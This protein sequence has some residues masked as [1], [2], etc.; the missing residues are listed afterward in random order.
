MQA[1]SSETDST[2]ENTKISTLAAQ[3]YDCFGVVP[4]NATNVIT[5]LVPVAKKNIPDPEPGHPDRCGRVEGR[6]CLLRIVHRFGQPVGGPAGRPG[7]DEGH[8][9]QR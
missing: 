5:P 6:G 3:D 2:G 4:V 9:R 7:T 1:G 8:G